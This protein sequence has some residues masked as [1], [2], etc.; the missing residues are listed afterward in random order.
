MAKNLYFNNFGSEIEQKI[1]ESLMI[2]AIAIYGHDVYFVPRTIVKKDDIYGEDSLS[3]YNNAYDTEVYVKSYDSFEGDGTFL[4]KFNIEVRDQITFTMARRTFREDIGLDLLVDRPKEGDLFFSVMM[5][6]MFI[7]K[8]VNNT[9]IFYQLGNLNTWDI[10]CEV[11]EYS[12]ERFNTGILEVD[13]IQTQYS[14]AG[15]ANTQ[16]SNTSFETALLDVFADNLEI[17][18]EATSNNLIDFS[19]A[20]PFSEGRF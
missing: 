1:A 8:Y 4:S 15:T 6:R 10:V 2:E 14:F 16:V 9:S 19:E 5:Q 17:N 7:I 20:D 13:N 3:T 18:T 11:F 12:N